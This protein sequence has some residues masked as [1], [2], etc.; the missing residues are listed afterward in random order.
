[1]ATSGGIEEF[2]PG[3]STSWDVYSERLAF[4]LEANRITDPLSGR[5]PFCLVCEELQ[6]R[7]LVSPA[8]PSEK[9]YEEL[10]GYA[11]E[12]PLLPETFHMR[13]QQPNESVSACIAE[14]RR[15]A[16]H[17]DYGASLEFTL[18]DRLPRL[19]AEQSLT[20][21]KAQEMAIA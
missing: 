16:E 5:G 14:L 7:S 11:A 17:C 1:M 15:V 2:I 8:T 3:K 10:V 21:K 18:R 4:H 12:C 6:L 13:E 20:L 19:L 9:T